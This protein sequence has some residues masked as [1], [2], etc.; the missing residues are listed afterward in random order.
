MLKKAFA[1]KAPSPTVATRASRLCQSQELAESN[2]EKKVPHPLNKGD[3]DFNGT[4]VEYS[5]P[6]R[7]QPVGHHRNVNMS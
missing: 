2:S 3:L 1:I 7:F 4:S 6:N 5:N